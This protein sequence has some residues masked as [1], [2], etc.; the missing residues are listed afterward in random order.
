MSLYPS[1]T[2]IPNFPPPIDKKP[3]KGYSTFP[4]DL[5]ADGR[6]FYT[7][8][9][10]VKYSPSFQINRFG[11]YFT[12]TGG[13]KLPIP[14]K[15][16]DNMILHWGAVSFTDSLVGGAMQMVQGSSNKYGGAAASA[17]G[18]TA[19]LGGIL[20]G[21]AL[22]PLMF[23]AFQRPEYRDFSLSWILAPHNEKESKIVQNIIKECKK[24]ASPSYGNILMGYPLVALV[25]MYPDDL[26]GSL[27][28]KPC[29]ITS[30]QVT[31]SGTP[32]PSFFKN[33]APT[34]VGLTLNLKEMQFWFREEIK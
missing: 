14:L 28:F 29:V 1:T 20:S 6:N 23:L 9:Q 25:K 34:V 11:S 4:A 12:P 15:L 16:N 7:A 33:G 3:D 26:F 5:I 10:F 8:I 17:I 30:V 32:T 18:L 24:A 2:K 13:I 19:Q 22:N 31:Y 21:Q 27:Y